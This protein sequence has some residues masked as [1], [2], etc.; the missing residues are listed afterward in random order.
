[1]KGSYI[2]INGGLGNDTS[3]INQSTRKDLH[4]DV[5]MSNLKT[6]QDTN[7]KSIIKP[8]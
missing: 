8:A 4:H 5:D 3:R 7:N 6:D 2:L 1:M